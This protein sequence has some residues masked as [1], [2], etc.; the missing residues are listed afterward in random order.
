MEDEVNQEDSDEDGSEGEELESGD[1]EHIPEH[2]KDKRFDMDEETNDLI[3]PLEAKEVIQDRATNQWFGNSDWFDGLEDGTEVDQSNINQILKD[4]KRE[5][6][7]K[8]KN[9]K[10]EEGVE[11]PDEEQMEVEVNNELQIQENDDGREIESED[12]SDSDDESES[13]DSEDER[14][15]V[16]LR[17]MEERI[18]SIPERREEK[19]SKRKRLEEA[20]KKEEFPLTP[21]QLALATEIVTS[22]KKKR[23]YE[24]MMYDKFAFNDP[25]GLPDWFTSEEKKHRF[26]RA[27]EVSKEL[28][29]MYKERQK[30]ANVKTIKKIAEA[31]ARKKRKAAKKMESARKAAEGVLNQEEVSAKEKSAQIKRIYNKAGLKKEKEHITYVP[32]KQ[33]A[34]KKVAR[35]AG[36]KGKFKVVD[37]R[38]KSEMRVDKARERRQGKRPSGG[39]G[40]NSMNRKSMRR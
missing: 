12:E 37:R 5:K 38:M 40:L 23:D 7:E 29:A 19:L 28:V 16:A 26:R 9:K 10:S 31:K 6:K 13:D 33:G 1:E 11:L 27:P 17:E 4:K 15:R 2:V 14:Q 30:E 3:V 32:V 8:S 35:P 20:R 36:V 25:E 39:R 22:K 24:E 18:G 21:E 34:G